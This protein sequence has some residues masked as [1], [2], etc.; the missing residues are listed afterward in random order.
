MVHHAAHHT[1][2]AHVSRVTFDLQCTVAAQHGD[3]TG[4]AV[5]ICS[6]RAL[7]LATQNT[8]IQDYLTTQRVLLDSTLTCQQEIMHLASTAL[9]VA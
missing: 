2:A 4:T 1:T 9:L 5:N 3:L 7:A 6:S 8:H